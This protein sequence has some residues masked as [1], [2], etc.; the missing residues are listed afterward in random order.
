MCVLYIDAAI[1]KVPFKN[2]T[3]ALSDRIVIKE[4]Q[5]GP[6]SSHLISHSN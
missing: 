3:Y 5:Y 2:V 1:Y 4:S 6:A